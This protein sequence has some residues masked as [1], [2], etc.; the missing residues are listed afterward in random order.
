MHKLGQG[1]CAF[2]LTMHGVSDKPNNIVEHQRGQHDLLDPCSR[3]AYPVECSSKRMRGADLIVPVG[4]DE[5][6]MPHLRVGAQVLEELERRGIQPLQIIE[7]QRQRVLR[8]RESPEETPEN[9]LEAI[10]GIL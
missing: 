1:P 8:L 5:Q 6:Q 7:E 4:P 3:L 2:G 10:P 9:Q